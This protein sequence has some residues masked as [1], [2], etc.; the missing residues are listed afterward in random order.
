MNMNLKALAALVGALSVIIGTAFAVENHF[1]KEMELAGLATTFREYQIDQAQ[2]SI[3]EK[4]WQVEDRMK[5]KPSPELEQRLRELDFQQKQLQEQKD[6][7]K[8]N[9]N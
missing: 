4:K 8:S 6:K 5:V 7:L 1:A 3:Q 9:T 2:T